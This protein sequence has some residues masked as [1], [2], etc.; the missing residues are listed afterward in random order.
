MPN[1][2]LEFLSNEAG[3]KEG[4]GE[5]GI[6]TFRDTPYASCAREAGQNSRDAEACLPVRMTFKV[7]RLSRKEFPAWEALNTTLHACRA[8][9]DGEKEQDFFDNAIRVVSADTI[10]VLEIADYNTK[11]L[12]GPPG[13]EGTPFHSLLKGSGVSRKESETAGGSFGIGKNASFAVSDLQMV[14]YSTQYAS[15]GTV[16]DKFAA[17]GK[18]KLVSHM[19]ADDKPRRM[20]GYWGEAGFHPITDRERIPDWMRRSA[21]GSSIY[22]MGFRDV[23]NWAAL[24]TSSLVTNFFAAVNRGEMEFDVDDGRFRINRN[25]IGGL[26]EDVAIREA[27]ESGGHASELEFA[28]QLYR[29]LVSP[30]SEVSLI[31]VPVLG[32][33]SVRVLIDTKLPR[34]LAFIRN[35]MFITDNLKHFGQPFARFPGSRDFV[36]LIEPWDVEAQKLMKRLENPAHS[37]LSAQRI[38]DPSKRSAADKAMKALGKKLRALIK[39]ATSVQV[40]GTVVIDELARFF[41]DTG[42]SDAPPDEHAERN[43]ESH[44][45]VP[46]RIS[47]VKAPKPDR[48]PGED[49]GRGASADG[50]GGV[51]AGAGGGRG[52]GMGGRG[53]HGNLNPVELRDV[54]N[55]V[56]DNDKK[57]FRSR[58]IHFTPASD[59][60][61]RLDVYATG[62]NSAEPLSIA[63]ADQG[64]VAAGRLSLDVRGGE[65]RSVLITFSDAYRGP[66]EITAVKATAAERAA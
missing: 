64:T 47:D 60:D 49:G 37:E 45:F 11:G 59:G 53:Q 56:P 54:R 44:T 2:V 26:L 20:T 14:L 23:E 34:R 18:I 16:D 22:C 1:P 57:S 3:E 38:P 8:V 55:I 33:V 24:M 30:A 40:Q 25:T 28:A 36:A 66:V 62:L 32:K 9:A 65:R 50:S 39:D 41:A 27:A 61:I 29:C 15:D 19:G 63:T 6:E 21:R 5:A 10:P 7:I 12:L 42:A 31:E 35:G 46:L 17:Q 4:L 43:P 48:E 52:N 58:L 51:E 13:A